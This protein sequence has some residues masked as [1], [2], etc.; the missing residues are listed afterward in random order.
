[1]DDTVSILKVLTPFVV[2][3]T[4][5]KET[6]LDPYLTDCYLN[7]ILHYPGDPQRQSL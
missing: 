5:E 7:Y 2:K 1:M 6:R 4:H 3:F